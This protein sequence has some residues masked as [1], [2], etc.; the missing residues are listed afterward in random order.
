M[1]V[2][3][4]EATLGSYFVVLS[5]FLVLTLLLVIHIQV[6]SQFRDRPDRRK[7]ILKFTK[8]KSRVIQ[9]ISWGSF[10]KF[11]LKPRIFQD[12]N[13]ISKSYSDKTCAVCPNPPSVNRTRKFQTHAFLEQH[14]LPFFVEVATY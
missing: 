12:A 11:Q 3:P 6:V 13:E 4:K 2:L 10:I 14:L 9:A 8:A 1:S 7:L 5:I